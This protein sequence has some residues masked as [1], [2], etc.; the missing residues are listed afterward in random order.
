M[1]YKSSFPE[2]V[3]AWTVPNSERRTRVWYACHW[4]VILRVAGNKPIQLFLYEDLL[5]LYINQ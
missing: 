3:I 4:Y 5:N 2:L 1:K